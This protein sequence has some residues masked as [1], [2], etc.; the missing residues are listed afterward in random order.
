MLER[1]GCRRVLPGVDDLVRLA[2]ALKER[3]Q[4]QYIGRLR[5]ADQ[6]RS[7]FAG[8]NERHPAQHHCP[9]QALAEIGF[10]DDQRAEPLRRHQEYLDLL[11][12]I[13]VDERRTFGQRGDFAQKLA[14]A[15]C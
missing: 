10:S 11:L 2:V 3:L 15:A 7:D 9:H 8:L 4:T 6:D 13:G 14:P 5:I 12:C 1:H